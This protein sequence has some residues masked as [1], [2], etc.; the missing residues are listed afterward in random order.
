MDPC[1]VDATVAHDL[2]VLSGRERGEEGVPYGLAFRVH[3]GLHADP[4][5]GDMGAKPL[6]HV[7]HR[8]AVLPPTDP[9]VAAAKLGERQEFS[10]RHDNAT[11]VPLQAGVDC[12]DALYSLPTL[13]VARAVL[14]GSD[15]SHFASLHWCR[16]IASAAST[17]SPETLPHMGT[18]AYWTGSL[19]GSPVVSL[20]RITV[21]MDDQSTWSMRVGVPVSSASTLGP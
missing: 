19:R 17:V 11:L 21:S 9:D 16:A 20:P 13:Q 8:H 14:F 5:E 15:Q 2:V 18:V 4:D 3:N 12:G 6:R 7:R 1:L 10:F